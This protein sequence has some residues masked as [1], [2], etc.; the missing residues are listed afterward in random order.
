MVDTDKHTGHSVSENKDHGRVKDGVPVMCCHPASRGAN[1]TGEGQAPSTPRRRRKERRRM[2]IKKFF[3]VTPEEDALITSRAAAAGLQPSSYLRIQ[4]LGKS[5]LRRYRRIR[6]D[7]DELRRCLGVINKA[8]NVLNQ[9][10]VMLRVMGGGSADIAN[11][12]L[13]ELS[14]AA[15]AI[16]KVL[17]R[18]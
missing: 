1:T 2:S 13:A 10:V 6:A 17:M 15:S 3:R 11:N 8:G 14:A 16:V 18:S 7:W 12:A 4:A 5:K 9:L